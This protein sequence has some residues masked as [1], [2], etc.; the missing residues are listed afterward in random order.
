MTETKAES[1][2]YLANPYSSLG[3]LSFN[4]YVLSVLR[5]KQ[6]CPL[7]ISF[8]LFAC[9]LSNGHERG[10]IRQKLLSAFELDLP[11]LDRPPDTIHQF[12]LPFP[13][14]LDRH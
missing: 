14:A 1:Q 11:G 13:H 2:N 7:S 3:P 10:V 4:Q 9:H 6:S 12:L 5:F 8:R